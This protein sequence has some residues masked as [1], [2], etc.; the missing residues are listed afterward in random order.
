MANCLQ[1]L[2]H[3][4]AQALEALRKLKAEKL[5]EAKEFKLR[6]DHLKTHKDTAGRLRTEVDGNTQRARE[7]QE[8]IAQLQRD[9]EVPCCDIH[10][11]ISFPAGL[12]VYNSSCDRSRH[13]AQFAIQRLASTARHEEEHRHAPKGS[14]PVP[15]IGMRCRVAASPWSAHA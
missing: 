15:A 1:S 9:I 7:T 5:Q 13:V 10:H 4:T 2:E 6:L 12:L 8:K 14:P 3:H 11:H